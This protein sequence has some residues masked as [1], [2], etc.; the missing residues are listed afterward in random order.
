MAGSLAE[1][2]FDVGRILLSDLDND[3]SSARAEKMLTK[4]RRELLIVV[5][6]ES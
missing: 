6:V 1:G 2:E 4:V 3:A 5:L